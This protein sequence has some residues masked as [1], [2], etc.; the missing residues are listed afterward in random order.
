MDGDVDPAL[1]IQAHPM[2]YPLREQWARRI[3]RA[4]RSPSRGQLPVGLALA[5]GLGLGLALDVVRLIQVPW[6]ARL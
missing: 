6:L 5:L 1:P 3:A 2:M 4:L